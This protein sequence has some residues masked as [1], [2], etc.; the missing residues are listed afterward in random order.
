MRPFLPKILRRR[1]FLMYLCSLPDGK[2]NV[3]LSPLVYDTE[4]W[5][6]RDRLPGLPEN[7]LTCI[8]SP[9]GKRAV[10]FLKG[11]VVAL[12]PVFYSSPGFSVVSPYSMDV[13]RPWRRKHGATQCDYLLTCKD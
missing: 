13:K 4:T 7:A 6:K 12:W 3:S 8:E 11:D 1:R 5:E 10:L 9:N 2:G